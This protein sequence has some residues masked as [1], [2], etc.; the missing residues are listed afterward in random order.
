MEGHPCLQDFPPNTGVS[1][2]SRPILL[3]FQR[4]RRVLVKMIEFFKNDSAVLMSRVWVWRNDDWDILTILTFHIRLPGS[5]C[6]KKPVQPDVLGAVVAGEDDFQ[7]ESPWLQKKN[8]RG[9]PKVEKSIVNSP[10]R[11]SESHSYWEGRFSETLLVAIN[12]SKYQS[13]WVWWMLW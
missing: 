7:K 10:A 11:Y 2:S 4:P 12:L 8:L 9:S 3:P 1:L 13:K 5:K 6:A